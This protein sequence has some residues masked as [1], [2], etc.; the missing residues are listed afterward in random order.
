MELTN[1]IQEELEASFEG[2]LRFDEFSK[3][4][5]STDASMYEIEPIGILLPKTNR[6][7]QNCIE[8]AKIHNLSILPR[9][10]GTSLAGQ[11]VGKSLILDFSK[12]MNQILDINTEESWAIIQPGVV[13]DHFNDYLSPFGFTFGPNTSTSSRATLGGMIGNNSSGS[14]SI[15][16]GKT[17]DHVIEL[18]GYYANGDPFFFE[19]LNEEK[20]E[21]LIKENSYNAVV[22][23]KIKEIVDLN[24]QEIIDRYPKIMRRVSGYN[25]DEFVDNT[26]PFN[27][28]KLLVG[29]EGTLAVTTEAKVNINK[30]P[31][32]LG[33]LVVHF[34]TIEEALDASTTIIEHDVAAIE[35]IDK[36]IIELAK[37]NLEAQR[38]MQSFMRGDP[39]AFLTIEFFGETKDEANSKVENLA[40]ELEHKKIGY[41][42]VPLTEES[43]KQDCLNMR[44][45]GLGFLLARKGDLKPAA[46]VE[47]CAVDPTHL[48]SYYKRFES[49]MK[50]YDTTTSYYGHTSVGLMHLRPLIN[51]KTRD[52]IRKMSSIAEEVSDLVLE[53]GGS[54]SGEHGDGLARSQWIPKFFG[55]KLYQSF[56]EIKDTFDPQN[57]MN[58]GKIVRAPNFTSNLRY[59]DKY[60]TP[61]IETI[62]DFSSDGG[63]LRAIEMCN[64]V[65]A[66]RKR[67]GTMCPSYQATLEEEHSTR[68]R[69]NALRKAISEGINNEDFTSKRLHDVLDLCLQCKGCK[70]ECPS[71]VDMAKIKAEFL[72]KYYDKNGLP[73]RTKLMGHIASIN[74]LSSPFSTIVNWTLS[75]TLFRK[76]MERFL[77]IDKRRNFP[78]LQRETFEKWF[79]MNSQKNQSIDKKVLLLN[80]TFTNYNY[81]EIGKAAVRVLEKCGYEVILSK[82]RCCGRPLISHGMLEEGK[83][84]ALENLEYLHSYTKDNIPVVGLEPSCLST[85][86]D[87]Y[88]DLFPGDISNSVASNS[89]MFEEFIEQIHE[90]GN[91]ELKFE[92]VNKDVHFHAHC[93]QKSLSGTSSTLNVLKMIPGLK[94]HTIPSGCCG[95]AGSF[96]Y[97]KEH[98]DISMSIGELVLFPYLKKIDKNSIIVANGVS[99]RQQISKGTNK[100]SKHIAEVLAEA[101]N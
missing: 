6:D 93:H 101:M 29:S 62:M 38:Y 77:Q 42:I 14:R 72:Q 74:K 2:E 39:D 89:Y 20:L 54:M 65:G 75:N 45:A 73:F 9:G 80:D 50:K 91:I 51:T 49:I 13:Q 31:N 70:A 40:A 1:T 30:K 97:E 25:L 58:P 67:D 27:L 22:H 64:G 34:K 4:I 36:A 61:E 66:C 57:I 96:G 99:C 60:V 44:K 5:Y 69:A 98:Y 3:K 92:E 11:T 15:V 53:F 88:K 16:Y 19:P 76:L 56:C 23:K 71:S 8:V 52:D 28:S 95:M 35:I 84:L 100:T 33:V 59:G 82:M 24:R 41:S 18:K 43:D 48:L 55:E 81:P 94:I 85:L 7:V 68:G 83:Q 87:E 90:N 78:K 63:F 21:N 17:I 12:Y 37:E 10:G 32:S 86:T 79:E 26:K 47:D 46:F